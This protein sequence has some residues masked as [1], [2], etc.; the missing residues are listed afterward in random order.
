[1]FEEDPEITYLC[2]YLLQIKHF[3]N[4]NTIW[5]E[6][7]FLT[8]GNIFLKNLSNLWN[9][10]SANCCYDWPWIGNATIF[11][12]KVYILLIDAITNWWIDWLANCSLFGISGLVMVWVNEKWVLGSIMGINGYEAN[13][14]LNIDFLKN[15]SNC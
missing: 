8:L 5:D 13:W 4:S 3:Q 2:M 12:F 7:L 11:H 15:F 9:V 6:K 1:M 10:L 14:S